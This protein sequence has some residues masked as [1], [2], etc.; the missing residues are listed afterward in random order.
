MLTPPKLEATLDAMG[1]SSHEVLIYKH[2][3]QTNGV[4]LIARAE[5]QMHWTRTTVLYSADEQLVLSAA[6]RHS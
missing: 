2:V 3:L 5:L 6:R 4:T 1:S